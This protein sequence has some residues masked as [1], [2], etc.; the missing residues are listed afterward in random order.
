MRAAAQTAFIM[1]VITLLS[2]CFGFI[3]EMVMAN[4]Y[5]TSYITDSYVMAIAIPGIIFGGILSAVSEAYMPL[6]SRIIERE[7]VNKSNGFTSAILNILAVAAIFSG[8]VGLIFS[9]QI[10]SIFASGFTGKAALLTSSF[11]KISFFYLI[12]SATATILESFLRYR[13]VFIPQVAFGF[14]QNIILV[15]TI[16]IS[17]HTS[18]YY[19]VFG[20]LLVYIVRLL[21]MSC[22]AKKYS[23]KYS[24]NIEFSNT[25]KR[26]AVLSLPV[27]IGSSVNQINTF[28]DKTLASGLQ[29]GSVSALNYGYL[30]VSMI[31]GITISIL[32]TIIYPK[33]AQANALNDSHR[34]TNIVETGIALIIIVA[35]PCTFG[36]MLYSEQVVQIVYE[37]G[38]FNP[39][40][41]S[42]TSTAFFFYLL[43]MTFSSLNTLFTQV[44]F[45][46]QNMKTPMIFG[47][48][49]V[50]I[51]IVLNLYLVKILEHG[52][53]ALASSI[54]SIVLAF[55]LFI[56]LRRQ[57]PEIKTVKF[58]N[59]AL[60]ITLAAILSV[61]MSYLAYL[62]VVLPLKS[63]I[64]ARLAQLMLVSTFAG[65]FYL[66]LL[67][68]FK[69]DEL[70]YLLDIIRKKKTV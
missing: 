19:L 47:V 18:Y 29:E 11:L 1:A 13:G 61:G 68:L 67:Y 46:K 15:G 69:I 62:F 6:L 10:V 50:I 52:G 54:S 3:R 55:L 5:G 57:Y 30:L 25:L 39:V 66:L 34:I 65:I 36:A 26:I 38:A 27:F 40:A 63:I 7:G 53:L 51:N 8:I 16:I 31:S 17:A 70:K 24:A 44:Y 4:Y 59:K 37:R 49:S 43:G 12:F 2:K 48:I 58:Y 33:L 42:M 45:S 32:V 21:T 35:V 9:D 56:T 23:F 60:K 22:I 64:V 14:I 28:V 20:Y 41:T